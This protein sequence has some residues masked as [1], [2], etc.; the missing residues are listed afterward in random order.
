M[1]KVSNAYN[2]P[3]LPSFLIRLLNRISSPNEEDVNVHTALCVAFAT[4][5]W[6]GEFTWDTWSPQHHKSHL[7]RQHVQFHP[8]NSSVTL[9]LPSSKTDP[10]RTGVQ[11]HL[12]SSRSP[13]CPVTALRHLFMQFPSP[14]QT[15]FSRP[16]GQPFS[17]S[18]FVLKICTFLLQASIPT[19]GFTS[20]S[21]RKGVA[22]TAA[23]TGI[24]QDDIKLLGRW[25][26]DA[27]NLYINELHP[28][29][30]VHKLLHLN[31]LFLSS[32]PHA[33]SYP[34]LSLAPP[35]FAS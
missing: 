31:S 25:K 19:A 8:E 13:L 4:F 18:F 12:S 20:H 24:S 23:A 14:H 30:H 21:I 34:P 27:V 15:L 22:V 29:E 16:Y 7:A 2:Y 26:S 35:N 6:C 5:L 11:I 3:S 17:K 9:T 28:S 10:F 33:S 1:V 32:P